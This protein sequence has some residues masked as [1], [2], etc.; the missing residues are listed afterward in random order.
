VSYKANDWL[1]VGGGFNV[2]Y[3]E[4]FLS[5][6]IDF[7]SIFNPI[8]GTAPQSQ[9]GKSKIAVSGTGYGFNGGA[10]VQP[11]EHT[12]IGL[13]YRSMVHLDLDGRANFQTT[14]TISNA[15]AFLQALHSP[16]GSAFQS[17]GVHTKLNLPESASLAI[18]QDVTDKW[19][20]LGDATWTH[21]HR[22][23]SLVAD[24]NNPAQ[25]QIA[26]EEH[27]NDT[28]RWAGGAQY[29]ASDK[30]KLRLGMAYDPTPTKTSF[31]TLRIP[32]ADRLW[33]SAGYNVE[34]IPN[35]SLDFAYTHIFGL[36]NSEVVLANNPST[37]AGNI[38]GTFD[39]SVN[40]VALG[41][42]YNF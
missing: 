39:T 1:S 21:W 37:P 16:I 7:G 41:L 25:P 22:F 24:F 40:I 18:T 42:K 27:W 17:T 12:K 6:A 34:L 20:L 32:D 5:N 31:R 14:P 13:S 23:Q 26:L 19:T 9:D 8:L 3:S 29:K 11:L 2:L 36:T 38:N 15:L 30:A 10:I 28:V 33:L 4:A 35:L